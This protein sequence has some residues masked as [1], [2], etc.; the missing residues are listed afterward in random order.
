M[1]KLLVSLLVIFAAFSVLSAADFQMHRTE[2]ITVAPQNNRDEV[3]LSYC[4]EYDGNA[5]G[6]NSAATLFAAARFTTTEL[7]D[8]VGGSFQQIKFMVGDVSTAVT[9]RIYEGATGTTVGAVLYEAVIDNFIFGDWNEHD[10]ANT[11]DIEADTEYW[12]AYEV[13]C[14]G[15]YPMSCDAGP[16]VDGKGD[17]LSM[18]GVSW[19]GM[20]ASYGLD[21]NFMIATIV[22]SAPADNDVKALAIG[23][24]TGNLDA[25]TAVTP[26][27]AVKNIGLNEGTCTANLTIVDLDGISAYDEVTAEMTLVPSEI[28]TLDMPEFTPE[29]GKYYTAELIVEMASDEDLSN[30]TKIEIFTAYITPRDYVV[31]ETATGTWC[32]WCPGVALAMD[33]FEANGE[34]LA[35]IEYHGGDAYE[36]P[37]S[38]G[39][40]AYYGITGYPTAIFDGVNVSSGGDQSVSI[41]PTLYPLYAE[42][43][44]KKTAMTLAIAGANREDYSLTINAI[45][46]GQM[47]EADYTLQVAIN[48]SHIEESWFGLDELNFVNR[49]MVPSHNGTSLDFV[50]GVATVVVDFFDDASWNVDN[51]EVVIFV[52]N[53]D[54]KEMVPS[55][56]KWVNKI[57]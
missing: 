19:E 54:T 55:H 27:I 9:V 45:M 35:I 53:D 25:G 51:C 56:F 57:Y 29:A 42:R 13:V 8:Y 2:G 48:E 43:A 31:A 52:Q 33:E 15:G 41:Y 39:R 30:N 47:P 21:Y 32:V 7:A 37:F 23:N 10:L 28:I 20:N 11:I 22:Q 24:L 3:E 4:G 18:D 1:K 38:S 49:V 46:E 14:S 40:I 5:I 36:T 34:N 6:T 16:A 17:M 44:A 50:D 12:V 26:T